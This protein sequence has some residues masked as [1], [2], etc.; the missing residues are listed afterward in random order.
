MRPCLVLASV[1]PLVLLGAAAWAQA[2]ATPD[3][4]A[5][6]FSAARAAGNFLYLSGALPTDPDG[7]IVE[8]DIKAQTARTLDSLA[9]VLKAHG[10][11]LERAASV[12][13]YLRRAA[14]FA[15]MN[16]VYARYWPKNPPARTTVVAPPM[17]AAAL[18]EISLVAVR[19]GAE[20][21]VVHPSGWMRSPNPYSYGIKS[22]DTL[23]L[24][25]LIARSAK[26]NTFGGGDMKAQTAAALA[27]GREILAAAGFSLGDVVASR[28]Y[29]TD[30]ARFQDMNAVYREAFPAPPPARATVRCGLMGADYLVEITM[31]A[32]RDPGRRA[33]TT[34]GPDGSPGKPNP[35]LS[36]AIQVGNRLY[37][38]GM[39]GVTDA[40]GGSAAAQTTE[41]L[42]RLGRTLRAAGFDWRD[43][44]ESMVYLPN[45]DDF[46]AMNQAYREV[47]PQPYPART[48]VAAGLVAPEG[49]VEIMMTAVRQP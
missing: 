42:A 35:V 6:P 29:I 7:T 27:N 33:I 43:V 49:L 41:T 23:F 36:S 10:C 2:P 17:L 11:S 16:E 21:T 8:G 5:P 20:R 40:T 45:P 30:T 9:A 26:D 48:T 13:V 18:V 28:V 15:A 31:V 37:L 34:P 25:G 1:L 47:L 39:L 12:T 22:G 14:D 24:A 19:D 38:S 46:G 3:R 32:V 4:P 44:V